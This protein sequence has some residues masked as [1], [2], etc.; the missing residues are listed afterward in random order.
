MRT[1]TS[2]I[3]AS[4]Y[5]MQQCDQHECKDY[6]KMTIRKGKDHDFFVNVTRV[7][8]WLVSVSIGATESPLTSIRCDTAPSANRA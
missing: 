4:E 8:S 6:A 3:D 5:L 7:L 1:M 2:N